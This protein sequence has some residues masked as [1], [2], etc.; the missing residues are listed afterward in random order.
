MDSGLILVTTG[1][2][3]HHSI[4]VMGQVFR[5]IGRNLKVC[6]I[7]FVPG[8]W[9]GWLSSS[10]GKLNGMVEIHELCGHPD[11]DEKDLRKSWEEA[12]D[13]INSGKYQMVVLEG[14]SSLMERGI[15]NSAEIIDC[16]MARPKSLHV[17]LADISL[18]DPI[19]S[20]VNQMTEM[21]DLKQSDPSTR[22][23]K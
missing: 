16:L 14:A 8:S 7:E 20:L 9:N 5:A 19:L 13:L 22:Q 4:P 10:S 1:D 2:E 23:A 15:V 6:I 18:D 17:I 12:K 21:A 3:A 11:S